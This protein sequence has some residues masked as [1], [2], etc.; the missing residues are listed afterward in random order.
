MS[1]SLIRDRV[2]VQI[3]RDTSAVARVSFG[4]PLYIGHT[5]VSV[6]A[7]SYANLEEVGDVF[8]TTDREYIAAQ[9]FFAQSPQPRE[10]VIG[11]RNSA[12]ETYVEALSAIRD[13]I[14]TWYAVAID[15][16]ALSTA[17]ASALATAVSA[18]P[19]FRQVW[20][21]SADADILD[22]AADTD[23]ASVLQA[24]NFDQ[25]RV[26]YHSQAA[27]AFPDMAQLGR[28]LPVPE[29]R[30]SGPGTMAWFD[31]PITGIPGD[32]FTATQRS[33]LEAKN[34]EYFISVADAVRSQGGKMAGGEWGDVIH[35][36]AWLET[37]LAEDVYQLMTRAADRR[38]K[39]PYTDEGIARVEG[40]L[41]N[42]LDIGVSIGGILD[43]Y[44]TSVPRREDTLFGD[45]ANRTLKDVTFE[46]NL[47]GAVKLVQING[48][49]TA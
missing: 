48:V 42:R 22:A 9:V 5:D 47:Q 39:V 24:A 10:L 30:T 11:Y 27:T 40:V 17:D 29:S 3:A 16:S 49:V 6:R 23:V 45:R 1:I 25:A 28:V 31:Q 37:R 36:V 19:G 7:A 41:R 2:Q 12:S 34:A 21:R 44:T 8:A 14:D 18:L 35:F 43:D 26:V 4:V 15:D 32:T 38:Q 13:V 20:F 33:T 46:A